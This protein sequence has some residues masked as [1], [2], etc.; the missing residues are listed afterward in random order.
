M[1]E[2][3]V[4]TFFPNWFTSKLDDY[5][6][7]TKQYSWTLNAHKIF[8]WILAVQLAISVF[9]GFITDDL[10]TPFVVGLPVALIPMFLSLQQPHSVL[11][12][13]V[14]AIAT[15]LMTALHI[16]QAYGMTE[17]HFEVFVVLAFL[18]F[19]RD[20][21]VVVSSTVTVAI[22]HVLFFV[23]QSN[24]GEVFIFESNRL[25]FYILLIHALFAVAEGGVLAFMARKSEQ[26][27]IA[28]EL[29]QESVLRIMGSDGKIDLQVNVLVEHAELTEFNALIRGFRKLID[30]VNLVGT[31]LVG[32]VDKVKESSHELDDSVDQQNNQVSTISSSMQ[33]MT[34]SINEVATLSQNANQ[35]ADKARTDTNET[36]DSIEGVSTNIAQLKSTLQTTSHAIQDLSAKCTNI[37]DVMQSIKSVAEQTNLLALNAAIESARAG[38]HGRGFAVVAD[39]VRNLAIK[40]KESAEEIE[41]ITSQLTDSAN[42]SVLN[43]DNCVSM[44]ENAVESSSQASSNMAAVLSG[45][46]EVNNNLNTV[47]ESS[48]EQAQTSESISQSAQE[49]VQ[50]FGNEKVQVEGL[51]GE[52]EQLNKLAIDLEVQLRN[53]KV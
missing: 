18:I 51:K 38:E 23:I 40:S 2:F 43:M 34:A 47:A 53:F 17:M 12:R 7:A 15:Q 36:R 21:K 9:I 6:T 22:H 10:V 11:S 1:G 20:W 52:I 5:M 8:R 42:H 30:K 41:L 16:Q 49:L 44:V 14:I 29:L 27:A 33:N 4:Y 3:L 13:H 32:V 46:N 19:F 45:I 48:T 26:E 25:F 50:L 39:E 28:A 37:S 31:S 35:I 24:G